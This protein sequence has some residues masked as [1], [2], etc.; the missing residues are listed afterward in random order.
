MKTALFLLLDE[1]ADWEASYLNSELNQSS[2]WQVKTVSLQDIV[3]SIGGFKTL[4]DYN[5]NQRCPTGD[6]LILIGGNNWHIEST[7]LLNF[8]NENFNSSK[9]IGAICGAVDYLAKNGF[10]N[11]YHHT[12][13]SI[14]LWAEFPNY[15]N[16]KS[17]KNTQSIRDNHLVTANGTAPIEFTEQV[18][19][20][21][22]LDSNENIDKISFMNRFGFYEYCR[23]F[24]NPYE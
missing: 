24:G 13:N 20:M 7:T 19:K 2:E 4:I 17:F 14:Q 10:L 11:Q 21:I 18:L 1:Y 3:T 15:L 23:K 6:L 16:H 8:I 22:N 9:P 5:L 12:G